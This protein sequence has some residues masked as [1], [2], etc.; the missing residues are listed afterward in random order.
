MKKQLLFAQCQLIKALCA[1]F[2]L[3]TFSSPLF[4]KLYI[5]EISGNDKWLELYNDASTAVDLSGYVIQKTD[6]KGITADFIIK[7]GVSIPANGY[8]SWARDKNNTDGS[9]FTWGISAKKDVSFKLFDASKKELDY[10]EVRSNLYCEG[11]ERTVGRKT[12]GAGELVIFK[13]GGTRDQSNNNGTIQTETSNPKKIF[14]NEINGNKYNKAEEEQSKWLEIYNDE[15]EEVDLANYTLQKIDEKGSIDNWFIPAN[16]KIQAKGFRVFEQDS[17]CIDNS[18]FIW[19]ISA[20][21]N[22]AFKLFDTNG[23][24]ID[25]FEVNVEVGDLFSEG[26]GRT[27]G[28]RYDGHSELIVF[29]DNGTKGTSN[30]TNPDEPGDGL[31]DL[32]N[33][34]TTAY[35]QSG[36]IYFNDNDN[37]IRTISMITVSGRVIYHQELNGE[38]QIPVQH[39]S[40]GIYLLKMLRADGQT[41]VQKII[42]N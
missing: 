8:I 7:S 2:L 41:V 34:Q 21:K 11:F 29:A 32:V 35:I 39:L 40:K 31:N 30:G 28:R 36:I 9:T 24:Q 6:E 16:T 42:V 33:A 23:T 13:S 26:E 3:M 19:G 1:F 15:N 12:D 10:F 27:V 22:V 20:R 14:I 4:A 17:T 37:T 38:K 5:N 25:F 18:T